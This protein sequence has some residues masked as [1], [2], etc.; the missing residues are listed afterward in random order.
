MA[1]KGNSTRSE[2][3]QRGRGG[4]LSTTLVCQYLGLG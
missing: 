1:L 3:F 2:V 4:Y